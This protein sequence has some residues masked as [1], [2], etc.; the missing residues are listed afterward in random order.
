MI[1]K[2][3]YDINRVEN[4]IDLFLEYV[5]KQPGQQGKRVS[6]SSGYLD[7]MEGYKPAVYVKAS[8]ILSFNKWNK[9]TKAE[10]ISKLAVNAMYISENNLVDWR[11]KSLFKDK[12]KADPIAG[13]KILQRLFCT[14]DDAQ[15]SE[16]L[17]AF[18]GRRYDL[19]AYLFFIKDPNQYYPCRPTVF[20]K[21]FDDLGADSTCF[22]LFTYDKYVQYNDTLR[23]LANLYS[24]YG[25]HISVLDAHSFAWII[26]K[27]KD[28]R[29]Y[30]FE[31]DEEEP[32][33]KDQSGKK[34]KLAVVKTRVNQSEFRRNVVEYWKE[35]CSVTGCTQTDLLIAS[36]IK[37]WRDCTLNSESSNKYNGLLLT[38][39]LDGLFDAGYIS[40]QDDG[41]I[42]IS[43]LLS[44][45]TKQILG[46]SGNM[47]L[48]WREDKHKEFL[49]YHRDHIFKP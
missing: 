38:P 24:T 9:K 32:K 12:L 15:S 11:E 1:Y 42:M 19:L 20:K 43:A 34:E 39:N 6:F 5:S 8:D 26:G 10:D 2:H 48:R 41:S 47:R 31:S 7:Y 28:V 23:E 49:Q 4:I 25:D 33:V 40:F 16:E 36:H 29:N 22:G 27:Y 3:V 46:L 18:F 17:A 30:I 13:G 45:A 37:P 21:A 14:D 35:E 44:D